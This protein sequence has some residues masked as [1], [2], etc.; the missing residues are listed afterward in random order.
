[1]TVATREPGGG[2]LGSMILVGRSGRRRWGT[3]SRGW[4]R[5]WVL[6]GD[7]SN[8]HTTTY[9]RRE[10]VVAGADGLSRAMLRVRRD[11]AVVVYVNGTEV[12]RD[13]IRPGDSVTAS[14]EA[15]ND[16]R[17]RGGRARCWWSMCRWSC[18][19]RG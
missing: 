6:V 10:V 9:F 3:G 13:N 1:M 14:R 18:W 12:M 7:V 11:D 4:G 15:F 16:G 2:R 17:R 5:K 8:R 19:V